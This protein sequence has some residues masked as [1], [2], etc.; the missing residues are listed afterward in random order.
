V[1]F[2]YWALE[3][4]QLCI[5]FLLGF[6]IASTVY[7]LSIGFWN[8]LS[9]HNFIGGE[10]RKA[11]NTTLLNEFQNPIEKYHTVETIPKPNRKN[12]TL[13]KQFQNPIE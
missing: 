8:K 2:F 1:V 13:L 11:K 9:F 4:F 5:I 10:K 7:Y 12:N 3:L 6:G